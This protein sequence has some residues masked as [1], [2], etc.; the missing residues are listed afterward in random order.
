MSAL[1]VER[2]QH[3]FGSWFAALTVAPPDDVGLR[4][5]VDVVCQFCR[6]V[7]RAAGELGF[8]LTDMHWGN[9]GITED[10][11]LLIIDFES[12]SESP[13]ERPKR[14]YGQAVNTWL[15]D[16]K[17]FAAKNSGPGHRCY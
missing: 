3:T 11:A 9:L 5:D 15:A 12:C 4:Q 6:L 2:V 7:C 14:R 10:N 8:M 17:A 16:F 13:A 1:L